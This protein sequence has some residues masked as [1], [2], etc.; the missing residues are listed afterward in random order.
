M[1]ID[2]CGGVGKDDHYATQRK[3][4][5]FENIRKNKKKLGK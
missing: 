1:W 2:Q 3:E 5:K 4:K